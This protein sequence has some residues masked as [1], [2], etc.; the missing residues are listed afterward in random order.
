M[1]YFLNLIFIEA[2]VVSKDFPK[3]A[4]NRLVAF[5]TPER[6]QGEDLANRHEND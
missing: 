6:E 3:H 4:L 2:K 5:F 1:H